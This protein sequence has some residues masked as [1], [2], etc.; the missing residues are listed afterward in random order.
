MLGPQALW[1]SRGTECDPHFRRDRG[2]GGLVTL[3]MT[4]SAGAWTHRCGTSPQSCTAARR[5]AR[6]RVTAL[7]GLPGIESEATTSVGAVLRGVIRGALVSGPVGQPLQE[8]VDG[9]GLPAGCLRQPLCC[10]PC[11]QGTSSQLADEL[12]N[13]K[14]GMTSKVSRPWA[15]MALMDM[16][17]QAGAQRAASTTDMG[18][19]GQ[20]DHVFK[21]V[22]T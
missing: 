2:G 13:N 4:G 8:A 18:D 5:A 21:T 19:Q 1:G 16:L 20:P 7:G 22:E 15:Q 9:G 3:C 11:K 17:E 12:R 14:H 6:R 10:T